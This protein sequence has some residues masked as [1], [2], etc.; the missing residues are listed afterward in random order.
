MF[1]QANKKQY[2]ILDAYESLISR[3]FMNCVFPG[4]K[5]ESGPAAL[6]LPASDFTFLLL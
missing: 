4:A 2:R 6:G 1:K 5:N 3:T